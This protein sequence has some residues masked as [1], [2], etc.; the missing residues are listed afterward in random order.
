MLQLYDIEVFDSGV[1]VLYTCGPMPS[2]LTAVRLHAGV[3]A[4][5]ISLWLY[6]QMSNNSITNG[7]IRV[8]WE[9]VL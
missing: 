8:T 4:D 3:K 6:L 2:V 9:E 5:D 7:M 1:L